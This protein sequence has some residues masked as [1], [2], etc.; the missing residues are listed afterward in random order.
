MT[1]ENSPTLIIRRDDS[2]VFVQKC[3][4]L[5]ISGPMQG[6][7]VII[8]KNTFCI[9]SAP[10][11]DLVLEDST[12]SR[13][14]CEI[15]IL[16]E[17]NYPYDATMRPGHLEVWVPGA[18]GDGVVVL[19]SSASIIHEI[20]TGEYPVSV[21]FNTRESIALVSCRDSDRLDI[22]N[23]DTYTVTGSL[24]IP[25]AGLGPGNII[26]DPRG[27]RFFLVIESASRGRRK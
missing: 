14:H 19:N 11:C 1:V 24:P 10:S 17:A 7:E 5:L 2:K 8:N 25:G 6:R 23:T 18:S 20:P 12:V 26:F 15:D 27:D 22:I 4:L 21:A 13:R 3:K 16:P 9:G